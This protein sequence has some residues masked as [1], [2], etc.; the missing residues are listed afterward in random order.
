MNKNH[1]IWDKVFKTIET[2]IYKSIINSALDISIQTDDTF[3]VIKLVKKNGCYQQVDSSTTYFMTKLP[4][5]YKQIFLFILSI[6]IILF[7]ERLYH[8]NSAI[9]GAVN[10]I[11]GLNIVQPMSNIHKKH[12]K[13]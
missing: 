10:F 2:T 9:Y 3:N 7:V 11:P 4:I 5:I 6:L 13:R 1:P 8:Y 12:K